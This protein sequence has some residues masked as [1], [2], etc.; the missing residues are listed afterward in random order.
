MYSGEFYSTAL[1]HQKIIKL[2][3]WFTK[4]GLEIIQGKINWWQERNVINPKKYTEFEKK[5]QNW[6]NYMSYHKID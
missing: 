3:R 5:D 2:S 4:K 1:S 6:M